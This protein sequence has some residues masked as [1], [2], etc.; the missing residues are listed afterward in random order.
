MDSGSEENERPVDARSSIAA[1][2]G[3]TE[4]PTRQIKAV[5][6]DLR[7]LVEADRTRGTLLRLL[8]TVCDLVDALPESRPPEPSTVTSL[9]A[10]AD[11]VSGHEFGASGA[12]FGLRTLA[13]EALR[14]TVGTLADIAADRPGV[15]VDAR[16]GLLG[17]IV[18]EPDLPVKNETAELFAALMRYDPTAV[19]AAVDASKLAAHA[20]ALLASN[21]RSEE[22]FLERESAH[23]TPVRAAG[24]L[25]AAIA[26][27]EP[28]ALDGVL[29]EP[30]LDAVPPDYV[31]GAYVDIALARSGRAALAITDE[32]VAEMGDCLLS[33]RAPP[34]QRRSAA[35]ALGVYAALAPDEDHRDAAKAPLETVLGDEDIVDS[36]ARAAVLGYKSLVEHAPDRLTLSD[37]ELLRARTRDTDGS[38]VRQ[39]ALEC[40]SN[41]VVEADADRYANVAFD[42]IVEALEAHRESEIPFIIQ[43]VERVFGQLFAADVPPGV[44]LTLRAKCRAYITG[45]TDDQDASV[46]VKVLREAASTQRPSTTIQACR[47]TVVDGSARWYERLA[48]AESAVALAEDAPDATVHATVQSFVAVVRREAESVTLPTVLADQCRDLLKTVDDPALD[49]ATAHRLCAVLV[50]DSRTAPLRRRVAELLEGAI[51]AAEDHPFS[52]A[53]IGALAAIARFEGTEYDIR[54]ALLSL[55]PKLLKTV[56]R[57]RFELRVVDQLSDATVGDDEADRLNARMGFDM[58]LRELVV[59]TRS[60]ILQLSIL[61]RFR[62]GVRQLP[63]I[64]MMPG[65]GGLAKYVEIRGSRQLRRRLLTEFVPVVLDSDESGSTR[66]GAVQAIEIIV[67]ETVDIGFESEVVETL[68]RLVEAPRTSK[69]SDEPLAF[70]QRGVGAFSTALAA[71][72]DVGDLVQLAAD[73]ADRVEDADPTVARSLLE[74]LAVFAEHDPQAVAP[75][76][77]TLRWGIQTADL[78]AALRCR[79]VDATVE[80]DARADAAILSDAG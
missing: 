78:D 63:L 2:T 72:A 12:V 27:R 19:T 60:P 16:L 15:V 35:S 25:L 21:D 7:E 34:R 14:T 44:G 43:R 49:P 50:D 6:A 55:V 45:S 31:T 54:T 1:G 64:Q 39:D 77:E 32:H 69:V 42:G 53:E 29:R 33:D 30:V 51:R 4:S 52:P 3:G 80:I 61:E 65:V 17:N 9:V 8:G 74:A 75:H 10:V 20:T 68:Y 66:Y 18:A 40:L 23:E 73:A 13:L 28:D 70:R 41:V 56:D 47:E 59:E 46:G 79:L 11:Y 22:A 24:F 62:T 5:S 76:H 38:F 37:I 26:E 71:A 57:P 48:A 58:A 67:E 36:V